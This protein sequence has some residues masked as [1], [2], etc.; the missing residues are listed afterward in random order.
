MFQMK[1]KKGNSTIFISVVLIFSLVVV[2]SAGI[3]KISSET[4]QLRRGFIELSIKKITL[5]SAKKLLEFS[6]TYK[7][8][9]NLTLNEYELTSYFEDGI[10][11]VEVRQGDV[12]EILRGEP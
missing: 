1:K 3:L 4:L 8:P 2:V 9:L 12:V 10:W 7:M 5:E 11:W 6:K